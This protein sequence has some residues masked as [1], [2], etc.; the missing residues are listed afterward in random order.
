M[1]SLVSL[2]PATYERHAIHGPDRCWAE[3]NCYMD[4]LIELIHSLGFEPVAALPITLSVDFEVDQWTFFKFAHSDLLEMYGMEIQE[5]NPWLSLAEHVERQVEAGRPI[6]VELDSFYLPDTQGSAYNIAHVKSTVAVNEI[7]VA[8]RHMG[9]FHGQGY[10]HLGGEEFGNIF[11]LD[12][13]VHDRMLPPYIEL[14]KLHK[15][16]EDIVTRTLLEQSIQA[17]RRELA[18]LP[19]TNPFNTFQSRFETDLEWLK[20]EPIDTFHLYSFAT[21]R[22]YG[23]CFELVETYLKWLTDQGESGLDRAIEC[24]NQISATAKTFQFKLARAIARKKDLDLAPLAQMSELWENGT[25][26]VAGKYL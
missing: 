12:G 26:D 8:N 21:L 15:R 14:M 20:S 4:V 13:L 25:S 17:L 2:D 16:P 7:D 24:F 9:Y 5:L 19:S 22:Q 18:M 6:L 23:A 3:T 10:Y 1:K 11:Q